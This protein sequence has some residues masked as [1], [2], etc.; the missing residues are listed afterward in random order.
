MS[1]KQKKSNIKSKPTIK[2]QANRLCLKVHIGNISLLVHE[3]SL[4]IFTYKNI[5]SQTE[6]PQFASIAAL[7]C[8]ETSSSSEFKLF[9]SLSV[10]KS[11]PVLSLQAQFSSH[12]VLS[13][14]YYCSNRKSGTTGFYM[15]WLLE[16]IS[17]YSG[18]AMQQDNTASLQFDSVSTFLLKT[19][20]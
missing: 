4:C 19:S 16:N 11:L 1:Q 9:A 15:S 5:I 12:E 14:Y 20:N 8:N 10:I 2:H 17:D 13:D 6:L 3:K 18:Q 7:S